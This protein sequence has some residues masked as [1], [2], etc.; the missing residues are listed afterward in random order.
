MVEKHNDSPKT[1]VAKAR[2]FKHW[3][4]LSEED[5]KKAIPDEHLFKVALAEI[6]S[7]GAPTNADGLEK[8]ADAL[9]AKAAK[10]INSVNEY[11]KLRMK[12]LPKAGENYED[13]A[14]TAL[15]QESNPNKKVHAAE[16]LYRR[17]LKS[18]AKGENFKAK[19]KGLFKYAAT[20]Q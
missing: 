16:N 5:R 19:A 10:D 18:G 17:I 8:V 11:I 20:F 13:L 1:E 6:A 9:K 3:L 14:Q 7:L 15:T 12:V 2:F 4:G